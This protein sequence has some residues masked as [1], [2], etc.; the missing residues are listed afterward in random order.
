MIW[1][2]LDIYLAF[3]VEIFKADKLTSDQIFGRLAFCKN[4]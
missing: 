3:A 1:D 2:Q 4:T